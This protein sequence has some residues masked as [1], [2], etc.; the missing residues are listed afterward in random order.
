MSANDET[1]QDKAWQDNATQGKIRQG[2][3]RQDKTRKD[4]AYTCDSRMCDN[5]SQ[6]QDD[7]MREGTSPNQEMERAVYLL[8]GL[9]LQ[10]Q[11]SFR[12]SGF[13]SRLN[14]SKGSS[15]APSMLG[16]IFSKR[17]SVR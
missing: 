1:G 17:P 9:D 5:A 13:M 8:F 10:Y 2:K 14:E 7:V 15:V 12:A 3:T 4:K 6:R 16:G 11:M